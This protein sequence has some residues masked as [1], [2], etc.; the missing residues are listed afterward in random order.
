MRL[1][2]LTQ[3]V[4]LKYY[5]LNTGTRVEILPNEHN[6]FSKCNGFYLNVERNPWQRNYLNFCK[7]NDIRTL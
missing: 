6:S 2:R 4:T 3:L 5:Q 7:T 1:E